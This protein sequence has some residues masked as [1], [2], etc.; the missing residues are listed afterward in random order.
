MH[1]RGLLRVKSGHHHRVSFVELFFDLVFVFAIT[2]LSHSLI[3]HFTPLGAVH[4]GLL[5][6][7][8]WWVWM[9]TAWFTNWLDPEKTP[10]RLVM[11]AMMLAGLILAAAI[12][13][14]FES[15]G[16][17]FACAY[18]GIQVGRT[19]FFLWAVRGHAVMIRN[20]QR[21]LAWLVV[22][23]LLWISGALVDG[24]ARLAVWTLA[25]GLELL[26][27]AHGFWVPGLGRSTT[28]D[29]DVEGGHIA[30]R[31]GLF[32]I[33]ALGESILVTG[34]T[35]AGLVWTAATIAAFSVSFVGS[36][37]MWWLYFDVGAAVGTQTISQSDD[38]GRLA[39]LAYTYVHLLLVAG[40]IVA[41]AGD[42]FVLTH[43]TGHADAKTT[44]TVLG[45]AALFLIGHALFA[46]SIAR[47]VPLSSLLAVVALGLVSLIAS[48]LSPLILMVAATSAL[49][50]AA[51]WETMDRRAQRARWPP[52][53]LAP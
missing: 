7:A 29:W 45:S 5:M 12:P 4:T 41:A 9:Y 16:L 42:E 10:V 38:P 13:K 28:T 35:F 40:I 43:P 50:A 47:R 31:C 1:D 30:E 32:I 39:R 8:V 33:I 53:P 34:A 21:I 6:L 44:I 14:A 2:Q 20:F 49:V 19:A 26:S 17:A 3:E 11:M 22:T 24:F 27:P 52:G 46:W 36:L 25:I 48:H 37:A 23:A 51:A 15:R 18:A